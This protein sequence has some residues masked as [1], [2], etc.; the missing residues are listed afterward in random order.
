MLVEE[1]GEEV[2]WKKPQEVLGRQDYISSI[3]PF[4]PSFIQ[5][6][7]HLT[8]LYSQDCACSNTKQNMSLSIQLQGDHSLDFNK[9]EWRLSWI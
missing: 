7:F 6:A 3:H 1:F 8:P 2:V 5:Q 4:M 9:E